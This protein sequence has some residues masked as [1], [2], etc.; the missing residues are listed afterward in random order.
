MVER[1][2]ALAPHFRHYVREVRV[3][4][5]AQASPASDAAPAIAITLGW[6]FRLLP[7]SNIRQALGSFFEAGWHTSRYSSNHVHGRSVLSVST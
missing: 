2:Y 6:P 1:D 5:Y 7:F 3:L 4:V